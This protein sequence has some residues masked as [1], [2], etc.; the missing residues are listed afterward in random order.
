MKK[1]R[2]A[3][4]LLRI[5]PVTIRHRDYRDVTGAVDKILVCGM[6]EHVS[7]KNYRS[8]L[9]KVHDLLAP[10]GIFLLR[11]I[12]DNVTTRQTNPG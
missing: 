6:I 4:A 1:P 8:M 9:Q 2:N 3:P 12:G 11:T 5:P 7:Y 10:G